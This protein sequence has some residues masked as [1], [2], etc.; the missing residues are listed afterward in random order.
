MNL[1]FVRHGQSIWNLENRFTGWVDV[2]LS[3]KGKEEAI[4]AG[5]T[6][7][8]LEFIPEICMTSF[9]E[10][11]KTTANLILKNLNSEHSSKL[12]R[13]EIWQLNERHYGSLQGLNKL[14]TS[15]EYGENQVHLWRRSFTTVP[16]LAEP[17][18]EHDPNINIVYKGIDNQLPLGESLKDVVERVS[19]TLKNI[20]ESAIKSKILVVAHGNSIRAMVKILDNLTDSEIVDVNIPTGIPLAYNINES[21]VKKIGYLEDKNK[22]LKLQKEVELQSKLNSEKG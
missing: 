16:P 10:R 7:K 3:D 13:K 8:D 12:E 17:G 18:S 1:V 21:S 5:I 11:S 19:L 22:L 20:L 9:L 14:E 15:K 4:Q 2:G 6:L